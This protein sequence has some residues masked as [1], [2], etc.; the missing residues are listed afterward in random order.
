M[1]FLFYFSDE[2]TKIHKCL[3]KSK[4]FKPPTDKIHPA[5]PK[6]S[7]D[8]KPILESAF[9]SG[10]NDAASTQFHNPLDASDQYS[11]ENQNRC[12]ASTLVNTAINTVGCVDV[13]QKID[14]HQPEG[15]ESSIQV[16]LDTK[17]LWDK[18]A[19]IGTEMIITK[20]GR[21]L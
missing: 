10:N 11:T 20:C 9:I 1:P 13:D 7:L 6:V 15:S 16:S 21:L 14:N 2:A 12:H 3:N 5:K 19:S 18:F 17:P 8:L 4:R